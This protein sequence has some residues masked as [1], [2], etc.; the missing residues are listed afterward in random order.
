MIGIIFGNGRV[1]Y[2]HAAH[3]IKG[4]I[5]RGKRQW[6]TAEYRIRYVWRE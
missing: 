2:R 6:D 5:I 4:F 1:T 3:D